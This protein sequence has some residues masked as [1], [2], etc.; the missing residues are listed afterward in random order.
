MSSNRREF[1]QSAS[2]VLATAALAGTAPRT[3]RAATKIKAIAF[4][5]F[6]IFDPR[7]VFA[8]AETVFPGHG[9]ELA[10]LWRT[11][12]FEYTWLRTAAEQYRDF[13]GVIE[14]ALV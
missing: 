14:E 1:L 11:K 12:I 10:N 9:N 2:A 13:L 5:G 7:P 8:R 4:D 6:P 3:A